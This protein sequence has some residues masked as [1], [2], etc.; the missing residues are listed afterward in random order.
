VKQVLER[1][2]ATSIDSKL[3]EV[4]S[5]SEGNEQ[6]YWIDTT[7]SRVWQIYTFAPTSEA[8]SFFE[9]LAKN[10]R[11]VDHVWL[12]ERFMNRT[13]KKLNLD[14]RGF[15]IKF[16]DALADENLGA[17]F[18]AK[19]WIG[20][21]ESDTRT[22]FLQE[23]RNQFSLSSIRFGR[24]LARDGSGLTG[25]L[26]ELYYDG[27][28]TVNT[29]DDMDD[30]LALLDSIR[31]GYHGSVRDLER[32]RQKSPELIEVEFS[33]TVSAEQLNQVTVSGKGPLRLWLHAYSREA[34]LTRYN[35][36]D[37][38]TGDFIHLDVG[39][40]YSYIGTDK[41]ACMNVAPR[42]GTLAARYMSSK[43]RIYHDGV[44]LFAD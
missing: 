15:G 9:T 18:S 2:G 19:F 14:D 5:G 40:T 35:G 1:L 7:D 16:T 17:D 41:K 38:H 27:H 23:A 11:G 3:Y 21:R 4:R 13:R 8:R 29:C 26:Y 44:E 31:S 30:M 33:E 6:Q 32:A 42:Y 22:R 20:K 25:Q 39:E 24:N 28:L 36:V 43:A 12:T 37:L 34:D 10:N